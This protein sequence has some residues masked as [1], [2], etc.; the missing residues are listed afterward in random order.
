MSLCVQDGIFFFS[1]YV[2]AALVAWGLGLIAPQALAQV[3]AE[4]KQDFQRL[5]VRSRLG[6][7]VLRCGDLDGCLCVGLCLLRRFVISKDNACRSAA[8]ARGP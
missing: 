8:D 2:G 4:A 7:S 6:S 5:L 3:A 1:S